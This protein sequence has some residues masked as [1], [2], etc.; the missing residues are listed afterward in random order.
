MIASA[1]P[2]NAGHIRSP[3]PLALA[4][5]LFMVAALV[6]IMVA[7]MLRFVDIRKEL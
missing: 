2:D 6:L 5:W 3:Q 7:V 1:I 4:R